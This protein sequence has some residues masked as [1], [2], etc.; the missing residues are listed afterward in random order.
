MPVAA[1]TAGFDIARSSSSQAVGN[2][3]ESESTVRMNWY[4]SRSKPRSTVTCAPRLPVLSWR[5]QVSRG[6]LIDGTTGTSD[7]SSITTM[8]TSTV[9]ASSARTVPTRPS[10]S[11]L[12]AGTMQSTRPE[13]TGRWVY[14]R[15]TRNADRQA[16]IT[17]EPTHQ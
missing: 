3:S 8:S 14:R 17:S 16:T 10:G 6:C 13:A 5:I 7:P 4:R 15:P 1:C 12:Y 9:C 2:G 11:S